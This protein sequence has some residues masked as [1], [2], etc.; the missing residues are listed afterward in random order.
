[1]LNFT[2]PS[3]FE[4][5]IENKARYKVTV[6]GRG[7]AK[8]HSFSKLSVER[9][10]REKVKIAC[11]RET[12]LSIKDS[13][14][15][16]ICK[17]ISEQKLDKFFDITEKSIRSWT[18]SEYIFKGLRSNINEIKSLEDIDIAYIEE[19]E[20]V[21]NRSLEI[22]T[23]TIRRPDSEIWINFNPERKDSPVYQRFVVNKPDNCI[24]VEMNWR[25]N[26]W[27]PQVL[28]DEM[29]YDKRVDYDKYLHVWEGKL[30]NYGQDLIIK[31]FVVEAFETPADA[32]F[33]FGAD[34]GF[35]ND[36]TVL[37]RM[38]IKGNILFIDYEF[39]GV[40]V[41]IN[42]LEAAFDTVPGCRKWKITGDSERPDTISFMRQKGFPIVG[43]KKGPGS[44]EDGIQF[45]RS[46]EKIV[47]HPR[48]PRAKDNFSN[49]RFKRDRITNEILPIPIEGSDHWPDTARYALEDYIKSKNM[50]IKWI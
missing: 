5:I 12:Q 40:G 50:E 14:H 26:P 20:N 28:R 35:S 39:Y 13:V 34:W 49:Y 24:L 17:K 16:L 19:A 47:I 25:D 2:Y 8:S 45:L 29:E 43:A 4:P 30:K 9:A 48:C 15:S 42:E 11:F 44:V 22:L 46:F 27:F 1:M 7:S 6:G 21:S 36:P 18:G 32:E 38:F 3:K 23:P 10:V 37:G 41:E 33:R 31:N